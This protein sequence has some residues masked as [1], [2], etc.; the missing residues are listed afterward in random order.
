V[1]PSIW[2]VETVDAITANTVTIPV[3]TEDPIEAIETVRDMMPFH[4]IVKATLT[5]RGDLP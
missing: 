1:N 4:H 5:Y 3:L 2:E